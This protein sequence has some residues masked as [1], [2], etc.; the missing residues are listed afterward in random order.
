[1]RKNAHQPSGCNERAA[2]IEVA[3]HDYDDVA[4]FALVQVYF[5]STGVSGT[6]TIDNCCDAPEYT[7]GEGVVMYSFEVQCACPT[8][9]EDLDE[10]D[11]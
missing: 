8:N 9:N 11:N 2:V 7:G 10:K 3:C 4:P 1:V 5:A 6:D